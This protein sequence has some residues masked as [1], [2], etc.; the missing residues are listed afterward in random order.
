MKLDYSPENIIKT[1][2]DKIW[3]DLVQINGEINAAKGVEE[4]QSIKQNFSDAKYDSK[5]QEFEKLI[6]E[7]S[8][9]TLKKAYEENCRTLKWKVGLIPAQINRKNEALVG[10]TTSL[11]SFGGGLLKSQSNDEP[12]KTPLTTSSVAPTS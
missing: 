7:L 8:E 6:S 11:S 3:L 4:L 5:I 12:V 2:F 10:A 9:S 1:K